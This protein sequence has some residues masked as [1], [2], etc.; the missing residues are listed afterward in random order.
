MTISR[1][2]PTKRQL[3]VLDDLFAGELDESQILQKHNIKS[4]L[5]NRW[6]KDPAFITEYDA[7]IR[8][9]QRKSGLIIARFGSTAAAKLVELTNSEKE[10]TAR[11]ACLD[12]IQ[13]PQTCGQSS[14]VSDERQTGE[15]QDLPEELAAI[16][17][18]TVF[19]FK[20]KSNIG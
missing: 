16:L 15:T 14:Q 20:T 9:L 4:S 12:I 6:Q 7:R 13:L 1:T 19:K 5:F 8:G 11:K 10:E 17:L 2:E 3:T 18:E